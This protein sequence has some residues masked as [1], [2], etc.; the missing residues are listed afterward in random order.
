MYPLLCPHQFRTASSLSKSSGLLDMFNSS[1]HVRGQSLSRRVEVPPAAAKGMGSIFKKYGKEFALGVGTTMAFSY[2]FEK[3][4][5]VGGKKG[6]AAATAPETASETASAANTANNANNQAYSSYPT[7]TN[8]GYSSSASTGY[9][10]SA[11]TGYSSSAN[12]GYSSSTNTGYS[13]STNPSYSSS[14]I[15]SYSNRKR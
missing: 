11:N 6:T 10:S 5:G 9:S 1:R 15:P 13:S 14:T 2:I 12:T 3:L 8:P 7:S 4:S